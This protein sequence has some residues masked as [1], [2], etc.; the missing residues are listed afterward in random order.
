MKIKEVFNVGDFN[1]SKVDISWITKTV[2]DNAIKIENISDTIAI[3]KNN[4][5]ISLIKN[6]KELVGFVKISVET[7]NNI[8]YSHIDSIYMVP[9]YRNSKA[10]K[11][12]LY[13]AKEESPHTIIADGAMF[14]KG[15]SLI[16]SLAK[17][18]TSK[19]SVLNKITGD[20][21]P[22]VNLID[23]MDKC[24]IFERFGTGYNKKILGE[25]GP[26]IYYDFFGNLE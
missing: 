18:G 7:I 17:H 25:D 22:C 13:S 3:F 5:Y 20:K 21:E 1:D 23:D 2:L 16:S 8:D 11:W 26:I 9:Q 19:V 24:Y 12:L 14:A 6:D 4:D 15:A 10:I